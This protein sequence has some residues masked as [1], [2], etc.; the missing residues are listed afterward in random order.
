M[1]INT[2]LVIGKYCYKICNEKYDLN[3]NKRKFLLGCIEPDMHR[4]SKKI[5]HT[6]SVSKEQMLIYREH[7]ENNYL[8]INEL[9]FIIGQIAHYIADCFCKY[10]LEEYYGQDMHKHFTYEVKLHRELRKF[11][12]ENNNSLENIL[13]AISYSR[14]YMKQLKNNREKYLTLEEDCLNDIYYT[15][16]TT[17]QLLCAS[18]NY[19]AKFIESFA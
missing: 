4:R 2:H 8:S 14:D 5:K 15:L 10:H 19:F 16:K 9:S 17:C 11:L 13:D 1:L 6:Y 12:K 7:I 3:L 18:Q